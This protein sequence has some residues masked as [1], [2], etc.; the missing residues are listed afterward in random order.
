MNTPFKFSGVEV[1]F[2]QFWAPKSF[3]SL[4]IV[5][6]ATLEVE[7]SFDILFYYKWYCLA[8]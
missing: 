2:V 1:L 6:N 4:V 5:P 8:Y 3:C 7:I